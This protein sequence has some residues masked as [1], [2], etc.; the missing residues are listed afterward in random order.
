MGLTAEKSA[1]I[2]RR[3]Q[4]SLG[5]I[6]LPEMT[7]ADVDLLFRDVVFWAKPLHKRIRITPSTNSTNPVRH[8]KL[9][10]ACHRR[11]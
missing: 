7:Q 2:F 1:A 4:C 11:S 6:P 10:Q 5:F 8:P 3:V 9:Q